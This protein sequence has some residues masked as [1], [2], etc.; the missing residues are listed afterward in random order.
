MNYV[1]VVLRYLSFALF[2][3]FLTTSVF[4]D[5]TFS[6]EGVSDSQ[7]QEYVVSSVRDQVESLDELPDYRLEQLVITA[8]RSKGYYDAAVYD[9][10]EPPTDKGRLVRLSLGAQYIISSID[11]TPASHKAALDIRTLLK[12]PLDASTILKRQEQILATITGDG[13]YFKSSISH[14]VVLDKKRKTAN[15]TF[16]L[17]LGTEAHFGETTFLGA[18]DIDREYLR[19]F[20]AYKKGDC[21]KHGKLTKTI[22]N[23]LGTG[24]LNAALPKRPDAPDRDGL[25]PITFELKPRDKRSI[26]LGTSFFTDERF[27][28]IIDWTN[29][30]IG[31]AGESLALRLRANYLRQNATLIYKDPIFFSKKQ[32]LTVTNKLEQE[33]ND[34]FR[35]KSLVSEALVN[36]SITDIFSIDAG[37]GFEVLRIT[38]D[39]ESTTYGLLYFISGIN[40]DTRDNPL[41]PTKGLVI[42]SRITPFYDVLGE[43]T[44]FI[45]S[46]V[47]AST[48]LSFHNLPAK[49][50]LALRTGV[51]TITSNTT[52]EIPASKRFYAGGGGSVRGVGYQEA[53]PF[54]DGDPTGGR[55]LL[56]LSTEL[57]MRFSESFGGV[58]FVDAGAAFDE[59]YPSFDDSLFIGAGPGI[60]YFTGFGP[61]RLDVGF[62]MNKRDVLDDSFQVYVSIGQAY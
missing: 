26:R 8:L 58:L 44:P 15:L 18:P 10:L 11:I 4:A 7:L 17:S 33:D 22:S 27:G 28:G 37:P 39:A 57:R 34:T 32:S 12:K 13:C 60:R 23:L 51:G 2:Y 1:T 46:E 55:S 3:T 61:L 47:T 53:G 25:V 54:E 19:S 40:L 48:Y 31:G 30:N 29:R 59:R 45:R 43:V 24:L 20:L 14:D 41:D 50:V 42:S 49:P 6:L 9:V 36:R 56:E 5:E 62:P 21:W 35:E 38:E 52:D 16:V